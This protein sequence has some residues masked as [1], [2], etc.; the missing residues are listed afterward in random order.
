MARHHIRDNEGNLH[1]CDDEEYEKYKSKKGCF[2]L[3]GYLFLGLLILAAYIEDKKKTDDSKTEEVVN[4]DTQKTN[5]EDNNRTDKNILTNSNNQLEEMEDLET[6]NSLDINV[7]S[8][9]HPSNTNNTIQGPTHHKS[10]SG[11]YE[12]SYPEKS[13]LREM[14]VTSTK[15]GKVKMVMEDHHKSNSESREEL[16]SD[17]SKLRKLRITSS[18]DGKTKVVMEE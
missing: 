16:Y 3:F 8:T 5:V 4:V 2:S 1:I 13:N 15:D 11:G 17:D 9:I 7:E 10:N 18:E 6:E 12:E 14:R